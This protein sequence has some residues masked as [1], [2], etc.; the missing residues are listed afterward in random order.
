[1]HA[2][3]LARRFDQVQPY[4]GGV[5]RVEGGD[6][7]AHVKDGM[8]VSITGTAVRGISALLPPKVSK[9]TARQNQLAHMQARART[10]AGADLTGTE[11]VV[12]NLVRCAPCLRFL[13]E[14]RDYPPKTSWVL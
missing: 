10:F 7:I 4:T 13:S 6:M 2:A 3:P 14:K 9:V 8:L 12:S 11:L 1:V 5:A